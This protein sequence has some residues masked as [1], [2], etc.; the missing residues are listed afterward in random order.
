MTE[1][2]LIAYVMQ[3][4]MPDTRVPVTVLRAGK[5]VNLELPMQ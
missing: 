3:N 5:Q 4:K 1:T 2:E